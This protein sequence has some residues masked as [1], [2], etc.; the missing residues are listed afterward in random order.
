MSSQTFEEDSDYL[1]LIREMSKTS[2]LGEQDSPDIVDEETEM[3][4]RNYQASAQQDLSKLQQQA[5]A[6]D[7]ITGKLSAAGDVATAGGSAAGNPFVAGAG[8]A[9][10]TVGRVDDAKRQQEQAKIDAY[11]KKIMAQRSAI[12]NF[13]A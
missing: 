5:A 11:N 4:G 13:F 7:Q 6:S 12:R 2:G 1:K 10:E 8:L 9:L 3:A